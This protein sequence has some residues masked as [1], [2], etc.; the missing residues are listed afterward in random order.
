[1]QSLTEHKQAL[2]ISEHILIIMSNHKIDIQVI[3]SP[4][5]A[6]FGRDWLSVI[7]LDWGGIKVL[8]VNQ[9]T[10]NETQGKVNQLLKK[11]KS[12]FDDDLGTLEGTPN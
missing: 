10:D 11:Y 12:V 1:M 2:K 6:L 4:G 3:E 9:A 8:K 7:K 5:L